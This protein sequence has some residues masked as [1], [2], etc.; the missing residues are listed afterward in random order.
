[1]PGPRISKCKSGWQR[2]GSLELCKASVETKAVMLAWTR[3]L[4]WNY[5]SFVQQLRVQ[6]WG[7]TMPTAPQRWAAFIHW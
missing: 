6:R 5:N 3:H 4:S 2:N 1:L 7:R